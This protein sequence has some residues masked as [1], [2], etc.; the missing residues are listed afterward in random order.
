[1]MIEFIYAPLLT[2]LTR[3][4][5]TC[6]SLQLR[7]VFG[8]F[9]RSPCVK[10]SRSPHNC[11]QLSY[12]VTLFPTGYRPFFLGICFVNVRNHTFRFP[13]LLFI[14]CFS[15]PLMIGFPWI[16]TSHGWN[17]SAEQ[18]TLFCH[19]RLSKRE[20][21]QDRRNSQSLAGWCR[22]SV[23]RKFCDT[24]ALL[25]GPFA[26]RFQR[27]ALRGSSDL[28]SARGGGSFLSFRWSTMTRAAILDWFRERC[29]GDPQHK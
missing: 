8:S 22:A 11:P 25:S 16:P 20:L 5:K 23:T 4:L 10:P 9:A 29:C 19:S 14:I 18:R 27:L 1:M 15:F 12:M 21:G 17:P 3:A 2:K 13:H 28:T 26:P 7:P 6:C 24:P